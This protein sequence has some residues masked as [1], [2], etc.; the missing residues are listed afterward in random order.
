MHPRAQ[1][2]ESKRRLNNLL[3]YTGTLDALTR[4]RARP[5]TR[6]E[7]GRVHSEAYIEKIYD[8][9][10]DRT[11]GCH[12]AGDAM[13]FAPGA[14]EIAALAAG[15]AI[16]LVDAV[17]GPPG[18]E[19]QNGAANGAVNGVANGGVGNGGGAGSAAASAA[20]GGGAARGA[21]GLLR[22]PGHHAER[23]AGMG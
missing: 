5:A 9:S 2:P 18:G 10:S 1:P 4:V 23:D 15:G 20:A 17:M 11:K 3:D 7:L 22:P 6:E 21:Y 19:Q 13:S 12:R 14:Y 16:R 8:L